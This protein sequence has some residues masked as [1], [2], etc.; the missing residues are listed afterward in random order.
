MVNKILIN[1]C[2]IC[3]KKGH[4][5]FEKK[6]SFN[7]FDEYFKNFYGIKYLEFIKEYLK[8]D[9]FSIL[10]CYDCDFIWQ[11]LIPDE[12]FSNILYEKIIDSAVSFEKSKNLKNL[13]NRTI[14][15]INKNTILVILSQSHV[16]FHR[17]IKSIDHKRNI[18]I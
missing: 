1:N 13:V 7:E 4:F 17:K 8:D 14:R 12:E 3:G 6:Y 16:G 11:K 9:F 18:C 5:F 15:C 2:K 10:K